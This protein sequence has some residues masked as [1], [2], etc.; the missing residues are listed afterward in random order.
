MAIKLSESTVKHNKTTSMNPLDIF[1]EEIDP[2]WENLDVSSL[3]DMFDNVKVNS[4]AD[5]IST[6]SGF[7]SIATI[8]TKLFSY[9][10]VD[11]KKQ[12]IPLNITPQK[13]G[14]KNCPKKKIKKQ[15]QRRRKLQIPTEG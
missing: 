6:K 5:S 12:K 8:M 13:P 7:C 9:D 14:I 3:G 4:D 2:M 15:K 10:G 1:K 11:S